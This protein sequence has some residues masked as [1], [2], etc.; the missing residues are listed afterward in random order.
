[1]LYYAYTY[2]SIQTYGQQQ[3]IQALECLGALILFYRIFY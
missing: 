3:T 1:M 2:E